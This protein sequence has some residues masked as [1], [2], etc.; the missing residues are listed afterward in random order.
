MRREDGTVE[1]LIGYRV[2]RNLFGGPD[3]GGLRHRRRRCESG[4]PALFMGPSRFSRTTTNSV[5]MLPG[6]GLGTRCGLHL[7]KWTNL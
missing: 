1:L 2:Q 4:A 6:S 3:K 5:F 7:R